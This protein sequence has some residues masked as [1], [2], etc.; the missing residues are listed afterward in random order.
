MLTLIPLELLQVGEQGQIEDLA[1]T[2]EVI[3]R[4]AEIGL[5]QGVV[6]RML[7]PGS[8][9][10]IGLGQQRLSLRLEGDVQILVSPELK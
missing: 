10:I 9:C 4:L 5:R 6:I 2:P 7:Q 8:P 1:G 3:T